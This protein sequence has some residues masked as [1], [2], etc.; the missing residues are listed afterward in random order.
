MQ[1]SPTDHIDVAAIQAQLDAGTAL[2]VD[3][4]T[5]EEWHEGHAKGAMHLA[6]DRILSGDTPPG[7]ENSHLY[8]YCRSGGRATTASQVLASQGFQTTNIG[9]LNDWVRAGG[10]VAS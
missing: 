9:G 4:R 7:A 8:L 6:L 3:V 2:L 5:D 10:S 1:F